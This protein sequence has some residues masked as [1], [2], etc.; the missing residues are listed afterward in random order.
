MFYII[1]QI[2]TFYRYKKDQGRP[3]KCI[4]YVFVFVFPL[5]FFIK[6]Y[7]DAIQM[8]THN[9]CLYKEVDKK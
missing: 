6:A 9:I 2:Y 3:T 1:S 7:V 4:C 8:G 5:I